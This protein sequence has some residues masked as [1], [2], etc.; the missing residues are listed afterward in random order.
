MKLSYYRDT[1][2]EISGLASSVNRQLAFAGIA[3]LWLFKIDNNGSY[4]LPHNLLYPI[5]FFI[6]GLFFDLL[7]YALG[8][9]IWGIY[10]HSNEKKIIEDDD[11]PVVDAAPSLFLYPLTAL[12][13]FKIL[14]VIIAYFILL[15]HAISVIRF[16]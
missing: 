14:A 8:S 6:A 12:F 16:C 9:L 10:F 11:D 15:K 4:A 2:Y 5:A 3:L 13:T 1:Y 7:Q